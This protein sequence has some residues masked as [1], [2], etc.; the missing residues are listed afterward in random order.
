MIY[1][2]AAEFKIVYRILFSRL[3]FFAEIPRGLASLSSINWVLYN[4]I[5]NICRFAEFSI[6]YLLKQD[7]G[8]S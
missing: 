8:K 1:L 7:N 6:Q 4:S 5:D 3:M 2:L